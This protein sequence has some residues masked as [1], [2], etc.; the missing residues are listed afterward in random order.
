MRHWLLNV[1]VCVCKMLSFLRFE[2]ILSYF[3]YF[4]FIYLFY[5]YFLV[6]Y[7]IIIFVLFCKLHSFN[8]ILCKFRSTKPKL[9]HF[10]AL[11][12]RKVKKVLG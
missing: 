7:F 1:C 8:F 10:T 9:L 11:F 3:I 2:N 12:S 4:Y 5:I 6:F